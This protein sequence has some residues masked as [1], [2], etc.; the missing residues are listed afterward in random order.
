MLRFEIGN[1]F[2]FSFLVFN[3]FIYCGMVFWCFSFMRGGILI[4]FLLWVGFRF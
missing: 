4:D 2:V 1:F 3:L